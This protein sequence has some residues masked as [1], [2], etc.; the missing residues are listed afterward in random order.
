M[1]FYA[2]WPVAPVN[3]PIYQAEHALTQQPERIAVTEF[4]MDK[5]KKL[6]ID[7]WT[8][9]MNAGRITGFVV[10]Q[11]P[12]LYPCRKAVKTTISN[13]ILGDE[14]VPL[15]KQERASVS[16]FGFTKE[17]NKF[18]FYDDTSEVRSRAI[19]EEAL[20]TTLCGAP[21]PHIG[22][23][24]FYLHNITVE[25]IP[26]LVVALKQKGERRDAL[27]SSCFIKPISRLLG[28]EDRDRLVAV[29]ETKAAGAL[30]DEK[31]VV[32]KQQLVTARRVDTAIYSLLGLGLLVT[33]AVRS[34]TLPGS[35]ALVAGSAGLLSLFEAYSSFRKTT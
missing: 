19:S 1:Q 18:Y 27:H 14:Y 29:G 25:G 4:P 30:F 21:Q 7:S 26:N 35:M 6:P 5:S 23:A 34:S 13:E 33:A 15:L 32:P 20:V 8:W 22:I 9:D 10:K 17:N 2:N 28:L 31:F 12:F 16:P 11:F 24:A 3:H